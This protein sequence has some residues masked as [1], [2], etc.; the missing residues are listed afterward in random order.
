[1]TQTM[2]TAVHPSA[3]VEAGAVLGKGVRVGP[4]CHVGPEAVLHDGVELI[5][6]VVVTGPTTLGEGTQVH[7]NAVLGG[8]PQNLKHKGGRT[9]L[10]IGRHC[11]I[12]E[13]VTVHRGT[14]TSR[15]ATTIG[16]NCL[17]MAY[18]HVA[19]DCQ[20]GNNVTFANGATLGGHCE[21]GDGVILGG[22]SA[23]HQFVRIGHHAFVGGAT[24]IPGDVIPF[25]MAIGN[26][27]K[28]RGLNIVGLKRA[29]VS[30]EEL[31]RLRSAYK[32]LFDRARPV[33]ENAE[34]VRAS[35]G[36]DP[37]VADI[38][39]FITAR[40]HRIFCVPPLAGHGDD[41]ADGD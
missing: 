27:A 29:G 37:R 6:H 41:E 32:M 19:H 22:L 16:D 25:G 31:Q 21:I 9:T 39:D 34:L 36:S 7:P 35:Y 14:D 18:A 10:T 13:A 2:Q 30:R 38:L 12:R 26:R 3:V 28:L 1:M 40:G 15:A 17:L 8:P 11:V 23:V 24:G 20:I 5:S 33:A 4:F